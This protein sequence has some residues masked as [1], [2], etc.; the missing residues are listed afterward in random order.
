MPAEIT[1]Y[2]VLIVAGLYIAYR[3]VLWLAER[4][5]NGINTLTRFE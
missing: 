2:A 1:A 5:I 4:V 3:I